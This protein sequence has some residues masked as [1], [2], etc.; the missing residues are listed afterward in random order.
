MSKDKDQTPSD[1]VSAANQ[2]SSDKGADKT[3]KSG[4]ESTPA[5]AKKASG[6]PETA[7]ILDEISRNTSGKSGKSSKTS[8]RTARSS[9]SAT[10]FFSLLIVMLPLLAVIA[11]LAWQQLQLQHTL[12][13]VEQQNQQLN[14]T[15]ASQASQLQQLQ[16]RP[17]PEVPDNSAALDTLSERLSSQFSTQL[18]Q[19]RQ[20]LAQVQSSQVSQSADVDFSWKLFEAEYL[21]TIANQK[22]LLEADVESAIA[23]AEQ[24]DAALV[25][26]EHSGAFAV[27]QALADELGALRNSNRVD[28]DGI[29]LRLENLANSVGD[30]DLLN[31]MREN[32]A[33]REAQQSVPVN[34]AGA[35]QGWWNSTLDFLGEI[36][37]WRRWDERPEAMLAPGQETLI[38]LNLRLSLKQA[39]LALLARDQQQFQQTLAETRAVMQRYAVTDSA[40]GQT[41]A[42]ELDRLAALDINPPLPTLNESLNRVRQLADSER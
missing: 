27:R 29:Y 14:T 39:Q 10:R 38:K 6:K 37:V 34:L 42:G 9:G 40:A 8:R 16:Q 15:L 7:K 24:A 36:F 17:L 33:L 4:T 23:L 35:S 32:F 2:G 5:A 1:T 13:N 21:L 20:Q 26:S 25:A 22:L 19:L 18:Q 30:L 31:S 11:Y 3:A 12:T 28:Q 41:L